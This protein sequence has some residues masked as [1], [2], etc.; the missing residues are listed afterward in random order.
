MSSGAAGSLLRVGAAAGLLL[1]AGCGGHRTA[2]PSA[3]TRP[4]VDDTSRPQSGRYAQN[5]DSGPG[6]ALPD[7]SKIPEPVP[8]AE[9]RSVYGNK[10]PYEVLGKTYSVLPNAS[11]YVER[12]IA[13]WY[14]NKF[15]GYTTSNFEKYDMYAFSAAHKTLPLPSYA[16]VTN[17]DNG[18]S[19]IVR[20]N[21]RGPFAENRVIDLSYVAAIK[22]GIWQKGTGLVEVRAID[23]EHPERDLAVRAPARP[24]PVPTPPPAPTPTAPPPRG[25]VR[26]AAAPSPEKIHKPALYLQV[27][28]YSDQANAE[29]A[30]ETVRGARLGAVRVVE[31]ASNGK[32]VRRV[33]IGPLRDADEADALTPK[34]RALGLGEPRVAIDD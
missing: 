24:A 21:D 27:G 6:G 30:A 4:R 15:H 16:R 7:V 25:E 5:A 31:G 32:P 14:G 3:Q 12:G 33:R 28:A 13:S 34:V 29:R 1:I 19:V 23:P 11:G 17:L 2:R 26:V 22:L 9:P 18:A 8:K 10:S 20:V